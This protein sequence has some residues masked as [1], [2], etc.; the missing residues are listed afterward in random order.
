MLLATLSLSLAMMLAPA[1]PAD[2]ETLNGKVFVGYQGWFT[3]AGAGFDEIKWNHFGPNGTFGP[4]HTNIDMWPDMSEYGPDERY[5]SDFRK[6]DGSVAPVFSSTNPVTVERHFGWMKEYG[7]DGA[8]LQRFG[9]SLSRPNVKPQRQRV[10]QNVRGA[11][12]KTGVGYSI[13]YD[14]TALSEGMI[15]DVV[16]ADWKELVDSGVTKDETYLSHNG[17]PVV[18]VWGIGFNDGRAYTLAE[19]KELV[20]FLK[21]DPK[22]GGNA[23]VVGVPY[24]WREQHRDATDD[25][26]LMEIIEMSDVVLPWS[27]GRYKDAED[28]RQKFAEAAKP[29]LDWLDERGIGYMPVI[30]PGFSWHNMQQVNN[31]PDNAAEFNRIPRGEGEFFWS[32]GVGLHRAGVD[33]IYVAMFD[34]LDEAT[35]IF[36]TDNDPPVGDTFVTFDGPSD[37][38]LH[39]TRE[40]GR[41]LGG[42]REAS[43]ELP[44]RE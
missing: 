19:C 8:F 31:T 36:K 33:M 38:F 35:A 9:I 40:I 6:A 11:S 4:G 21:N 7:I 13:M 26:M 23:V 15:R 29:D 34:E 5:P 2:Q 28:A 27:V 12:A 10:L 37:H 41:L 42:E 20:E 1:T 14:L 39:L 16:I 18:A 3:A 22:Y 43:D 32:Q 24:W 17:K 30:Y 44:T 25:P